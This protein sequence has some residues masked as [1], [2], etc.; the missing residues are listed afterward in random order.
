MLGLGRAL[1]ETMAVLMILS[2]RP[3]VLD[4]AAAGI[5]EPDHRGEHRGA[6]PGSDPNIGVPVLIGTGLVLFVITFLVNFVARKITE[7]ASA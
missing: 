3:D 1:G 7:K 2:P 4:Q 6:I 5:P